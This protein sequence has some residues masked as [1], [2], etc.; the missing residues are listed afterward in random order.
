MHTFLVFFDSAHVVV[1]HAWKTQW[2]ETAE[3]KKTTFLTSWPTSFFSFSWRN[4][5]CCLWLAPCFKRQEQWRVREVLGNKTLRASLINIVYEF[6]CY[7]SLVI[8]LKSDNL[9][10]QPSKSVE[11]LQLCI[12]PCSSLYS[13]KF[14]MTQVRRHWKKGRFK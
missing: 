7:Y 13:N 9:S 2:V 1:L 10:R 4:M 8:K 5:Q 3:E 12:S 11:F 14:H 6:V